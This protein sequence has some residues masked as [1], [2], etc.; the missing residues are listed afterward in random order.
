MII[1]VLILFIIIVVALL[2][3]SS[4]ANSNDDLTY[5]SDIPE[6]DFK[7]LNLSKSVS[8]NNKTTKPKTYVKKTT[9]TKNGVTVTTELR[10]SER[11]VNA[12][13]IHNE[14]V[15]KSSNPKWHRSE[16]EKQLSFDFSFNNR[17]IIDRYEALMIN[18]G[19]PF[20]SSVDVLSNINICEASLQAFNDLKQ[21]CYQSEGGKIYFQDMWEYCHNSKNECFAWSDN[22]KERIKYLNDNKELLLD[23]DLKLPTLS[24]DLLNYLKSHT[25]AIQKD[26]YSDFNPLLKSEIQKRLRDFEKDNI[27][28]RTKYKSSYLIELL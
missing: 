18:E 26:I 9:E 6:P 23:K 13:R 2:V 11:A 27:I 8:Q 25:N 20:D 22:L 4:K 17:Q 12:M 16:Y 10:I 15:A 7:P 24:N 21:F 14:Y 1:F 5:K 3:H 28:R 19:K